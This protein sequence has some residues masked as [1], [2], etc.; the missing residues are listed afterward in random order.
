MVK[1]NLPLRRVRASRRGTWKWS[2][3]KIAR[4]SGDH[5]HTGKP[6][7]YHG[8]IPCR[9]ASS[10]RDGRKSP[11]IDSNPLGSARSGFGKTAMAGQIRNPKSETNPN[12]QISNVETRRAARRQPAV[13]DSDTVSFI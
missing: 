6:S 13:G 11:P 5:Q 3:S 8:K 10:T 9:Y 7:S 1:L 2:R 4:G 12:V